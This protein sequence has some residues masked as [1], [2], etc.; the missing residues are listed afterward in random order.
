MRKTFIDFMSRIIN[1]DERV[2]FI[3]SD[4]GAGTLREAQENHPHRIFMEGISE[5]H[6]VGMAAG[7]AMEG[8]VPFVHTIGTFLTRRSY[9][10]AAIDVGLHGLPVRLI[11]GGGGMTYAPLGPTHQAIEDISL[12]TSIPGMNVFCP[13]DPAEMELGLSQSLSLKSP[14]YIRVGKGGEPDATS[15]LQASVPG[16]AR[17]FDGGSDYVVATTGSLLHEGLKAQKQLQSI[18]ISG[19]IGHFPWVSPLDATAA[20][21]LRAMNCPVIIFEEH[22]PRGG[23]TTAL[24]HQWMTNGAPPIVRSLTLLSSFAENYGSQS[25]HWAASG[26]DAD[27][28]AQTIK[29]LQ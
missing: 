3:G 12:M 16:Q 1:V 5:Q 4:L 11:G 29:D 8:F 27:S 21:S 25:E 22:V 2:V 24:L 18:G 19:S 28:L 26:L 6:I 23:L 10:Q 9:E 13:A 14:L 20:E 17:W 7:L 15:R